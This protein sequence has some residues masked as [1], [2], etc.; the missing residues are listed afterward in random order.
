MHCKYVCGTLIEIS[1]VNMSDF[2]RITLLSLYQARS[3]GFK[4]G[5]SD[6]N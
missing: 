5:G 2:F 4:L 6:F 1:G 3:Q